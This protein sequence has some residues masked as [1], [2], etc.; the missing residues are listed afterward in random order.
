MVVGGW[1]AGN[2][3][4][5][6]SPL[7]PGDPGNSDCG[8]DQKRLVSGSSLGQE[9]RPRRGSSSAGARRARTVR[10]ATAGSMATF[11]ANA[12]APGSFCFWGLRGGRVG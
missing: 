3:Q 4:R 9:R 11:R 1:G 12:L 8:K 10:G 2:T 7:V 5:A 6:F